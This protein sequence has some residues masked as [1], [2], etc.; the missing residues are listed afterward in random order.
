MLPHAIYDNSDH[1]SAHRIKMTAEKAL[2]ADPVASTAKLQALNAPVLQRRQMPSVA[3]VVLGLATKQDREPA[4]CVQAAARII[5]P[6][7]ASA[8]FRAAQKRAGGKLPAKRLS[9]VARRHGPIELR[10]VCRRD[11][12]K[13]GGRNVIG[14]DPI[15]SK[16][17]GGRCPTRNSRRLSHTPRRTAPENV[18]PPILR[19]SPDQRR[20][21]LG[22]HDTPGI[23]GRAD[24]HP[25]SAKVARCWSRWLAL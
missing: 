22:M 12:R 20:I 15:G 25:L 4:A 18:T 19:Q 5:L 2:H 1:W 17:G 11:C 24:S 9:Q 16:A 23:L 3:A 6:A 21:A 13:I 14:L 7:E 10:R 8:M